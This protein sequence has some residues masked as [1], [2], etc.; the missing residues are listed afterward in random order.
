VI[1]NGSFL[2]LAEGVVLVQQLLVARLLSTSQ[3]GLYGIV[4][5]T[6][7]SLLTL[8]QVGIDQQYVQQDEADQELAFQRAF[9]LELTLGAI[10]AGLVVLL[11]PVIATVYG[12]WTLAPLMLALAYLPVAFA[13]QAPA[14]IFFRRMDF[15]RQRV[16]QSAAPI[17]TFA[18]TLALLLAG[19]EVWALVL[20]ALAGN[21]V[22]AGIALRLSPYR[23][24]L[25]F[26]RATARVYARFSWPIL[27][28][29]VAGLVIRQGQVFAFDVHLGLAGAG[30]ITLAVT[31][32]RYA[33]RADQIVTTT[34]YPAICAVTDR[35]DVMT[36][37]F[38]KSNR[39]TA[40]WALPFGAGLALFSPDLVEYVLGDKWQP[41]VILLQLMGITGAV[42]QLGFN[43]TAFYRAVGISWP[44]AV[45][46]LAAA[47]AFCAGPVPLLFAYGI[48]GF[49][50]GM[51]AV[52]AAAWGTR[53]YF[54]KKLL[55]D[56]RLVALA[57]RAL[58]PT[59]AASL[60]VLLARLVEPGDG[61]LGVAL[62]ELALFVVSYAVF[63]W[64]RERELLAEMVGYLRRQTTPPPAPDPA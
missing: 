36:E 51:F 61:G 16:V 14:W 3:V 11:A 9:T 56:V 33:D 54:I 58:V 34:I 1:V 27:L 29:A 18:A 62:G 19:L 38:V 26:D 22:A 2:L 31:L 44:Q 24:R 8:K 40:M 7:I 52:M 37:M 12:D 6:V 32:T 17:A 49:A 23:L 53:A 30:F 59:V 60:V 13:L 41:A 50:W 28:A 43:W 55:P 5:I 35:K 25:R 47:A 57:V 39:V 21:L 20:G 10:F 64:L 48:E 42:H 45:Y 46:A 4:S 63:T 15:I